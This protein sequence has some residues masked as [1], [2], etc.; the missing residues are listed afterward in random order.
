MTIVVFVHTDVPSGTTIVNTATAF[1]DSFDEVTLDNGKVTFDPDGADASESTYVEAEAM[2]SIE[3][4]D[5][6][7]AM[8][9]GGDG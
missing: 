4:D 6:G 1:S 7:E 5:L 3:K 2:L 9:A 8:V